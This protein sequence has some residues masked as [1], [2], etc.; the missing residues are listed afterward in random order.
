MKKILI[1]T[2][3]FF[4]VL[5]ANDNK[6]DNNFRYRI[7]T[8]P[9]IVGGLDTKIEYLFDILPIDKSRGF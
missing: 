2:L 7:D 4:G 9:L 5:N 6:N 8:F 3:L 1:I